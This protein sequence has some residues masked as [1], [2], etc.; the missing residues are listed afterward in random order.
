MYCKLFSFSASIL[1]SYSRGFPSVDLVAG[2]S[3]PG[4]NYIEAVME[5]I[6]FKLQFELFRAGT[7]HILSGPWLKCMR[8]VNFAWSFI[9]ILLLAISYLNIW[10]SCVHCE[11]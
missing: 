5:G 4:F 10:M 6:Q 11:A 7:V 9:I 1:Y 8:A 3:I 2:P